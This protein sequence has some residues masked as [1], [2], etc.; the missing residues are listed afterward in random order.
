MLQS[1]EGAH[2]VAHLIVG[3][4]P[5][6]LLVGEVVEGLVATYFL[7]VV[8]ERHTIERVVEHGKQIF[9]VAIFC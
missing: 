5:V 8:D 1:I 9:V 6:Y 3:V 4:V 7:P 2:G